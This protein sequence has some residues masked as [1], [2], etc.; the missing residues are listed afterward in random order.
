MKYLKVFNTESEYQ[1]FKD[2]DDYV[3]PNVSYIK[4]TEDINLKPYTPPSSVGDVAYWSGSKVKTTPLSSWNTSLGTPVGVVVVPSGFAPDGK[5][6]IASLMN[7]DINGNQVN[8]YTTMEW[9]PELVDTSLINYTKVPTTDNAGS[10]STGSNGNGYLPSDMFTGTTSFVDPKAKYNETYNLIPSPYLG[11]SPNPEYYKTISGGNAYSD[12]NG[13]SNTQTL[14]NL[15]INY[16]AANAAWKYNDNVCNLQWYLPSMGELGY[17]IVRMKAINNTIIRLNGLTI[18]FEGNSSYWSSTEKYDSGAYKI[19][20]TGVLNSGYKEYYG[21][22][23]RP[24]A[25]LD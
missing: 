7:S 6:R 25:I 24:F 23:V 21:A 18:D 22:F 4:E 8:Y 14:V 17:L 11:D 9:G 5:I 12:F 13:L 20:T 1:T 16:Y 10:T 15:G 2:G 3:T 19:G